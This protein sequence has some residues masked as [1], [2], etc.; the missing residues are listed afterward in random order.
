MGTGRDDQS[1]PEEPEPEIKVLGKEDPDIEGN[2][3]NPEIA[4]VGG[5]HGDEKCGVEAIDRILSIRP[6][7]KRPV[8]LVKANPAAIARNKRYIDTDLNRQFE[9]DVP[10]K[11]RERVL[12]KVLAKEL[13]GCKTLSIHSTESVEY[14]VA[15][16]TGF[17]RFNMDVCMQMSTNFLVD[18]SNVLGR[19]PFAGDADLIE[20]EAG[21]YETESDSPSDSAYENAFRACLEFL[22]AVDALPGTNSY[23]GVDMYVLEG[24]LKKHR[25]NEVLVE[26]PEPEREYEVLVEN[27]ERVKEGEP[28]AKIDGKVQYAAHEF[29][30]VVFSAD[31]YSDKFGFWSR[32]H[33]RLEAIQ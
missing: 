25:E 15:F 12:A 29:W 8:K 20:L 31:G 27:F 24:E 16:A 28:Y 14:P 9:D 10:K 17:D 7:V 23:S 11:A 4:I 19:R 33:G 6:K 30:P 3:E 32:P 22:T 2:P 18:V 1:E 13:S 21:L 5:V 26:D